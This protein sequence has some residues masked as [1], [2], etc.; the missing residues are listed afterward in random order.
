MSNEAL[1][2]SSQIDLVGIILDVP[3]SDVGNGA[4]RICRE[5]TLTLQLGSGEFPASTDL[6]ADTRHPGR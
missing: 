5:Q 3:I 4:V 2:T 1:L 6:Q